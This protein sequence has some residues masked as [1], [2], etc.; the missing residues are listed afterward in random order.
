[1]VPSTA[2]ESLAGDTAMIDALFALNAEHMDLEGL[3]SLTWTFL[4]MRKP[5]GLRVATRKPTSIYAIIGKCGEEI[6]G[7]RHS[8]E[9]GKF[10]IVALSEDDPSAPGRVIFESDSGLSDAWQSSLC[11][12][13]GTKIYHADNTNTVLQL[14]GSRMQPIKA[15]VPKSA[16]LYR[17][18]LR[19]STLYVGCADGRSI[20]RNLCAINL[21]SG[22]FEK[23]KLDGEEVD[24]LYSFDV[25][26]TA[27]GVLRRVAYLR[28]CKGHPRLELVVATVDDAG[29]VK[30]QLKVPSTRGGT[31]FRFL[32][33]LDGILC[34]VEGSKLRLVDVDST[35]ELGCC[36]IGTT[37][38][39]LECATDDVIRMISLNPPCGAEVVDIDVL[40]R[41]TQT[42]ENLF[43]L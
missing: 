3:K 8:L 41:Y 42:S 37:G 20:S 30:S 29:A 13:G 23:V 34:V 12:D 40:Y 17:T 26:H 24:F 38:A 11:T 43:T 27:S 22:K 14:S 28:P 4:G 15:D 33:H 5:C 7:L 16:S 1:M 35:M 36:D 9:M 25:E 10:E 19:G 21:E 2:P 31:H 39:S 32:P 6:I 18:R